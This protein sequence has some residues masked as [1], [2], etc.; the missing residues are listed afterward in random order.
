MGAVWS[1]KK[2][3]PIIKTLGSLLRWRLLALTNDILWVGQST[4][5]GLVL[6]GALQ[7][8]VGIHAVN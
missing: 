1:Y 3:D 6:A 2:A 5:G 8:A 7:T 4:T